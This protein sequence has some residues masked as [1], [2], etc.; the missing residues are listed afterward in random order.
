M[1]G[2]G[3]SSHQLHQSLPTAQDKIERCEKGLETQNETEKS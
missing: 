2:W 3:H 1:C